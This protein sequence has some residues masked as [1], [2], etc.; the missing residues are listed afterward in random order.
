MRV[1]ED[2]L[3]ELLK[4]FRLG[5]TGSNIQKLQTD[6]GIKD[7][8]LVYWFQDKEH[9]NLLLQYLGVDAT[10]VSEISD[11]QILEVINA[12]FSLTGSSLFVFLHIYRGGVNCSSYIY[13]R[14]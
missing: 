12:F 14:I 10:K 8:N 7:Q 9:I 11:S 5:I 3:K 13:Y 1:R 6:S 4:Q 2:T